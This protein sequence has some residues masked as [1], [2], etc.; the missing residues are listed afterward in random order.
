MC[1]FGLVTAQALVIFEP[2]LVL[3]LIGAIQTQLEQMI[4]Q[5]RELSNKMDAVA[6]VLATLTQ[7]V[8][9]LAQ[10]AQLL[11]PPWQ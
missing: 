10:A 11:P 9:S 7:Q 3:S 1:Q 2:Q 8:A 4:Q 5:Q 6:A